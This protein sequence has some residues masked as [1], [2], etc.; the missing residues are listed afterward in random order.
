MGRG[1]GNLNTELFM[2]Y[3]NENLGTNYKVKPLLNIIDEILNVFYERNK[4]GYSLPNYL[5]AMYSTHPNYAGYLDD[6]NTLTIENMDEIFRIMSNEKRSEF[7]KEYIEELYIRYMS[8]GEKQEKNLSE[9]T[10]RLMNKK[11]LLIAPGTSSIDEKDKILNYIKNQNVTVISVN[12]DYQFYNT[13]YIFISNNRRFKQLDP[14]KRK[15]CIVTSN[16][17]ADNIYL[18]VSYKSLINNEEVIKDNAGMM[19]IQFFILLGVKE[20]YLAGFDGYSKDIRNNYADVQM[21]LVMKNAVIDLMNDSMTRV[22]NQ[23]NKQVNIYFLTKP[24]YIRFQ[25]L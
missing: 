17:P 18:Q 6:K 25:N 13:E 20:I 8:T 16:I 11:I 4:W 19:A 12:F 2:Q 3:M 15:K 7:D 24:K 10:Q 23:Y 22:I 21:E 9:I 14:S 1:A 5:S